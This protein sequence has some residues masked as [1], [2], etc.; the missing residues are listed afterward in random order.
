VETLLLDVL[1]GDRYLL[2]SDGLSQYADDTVL[3]QHLS[4]DLDGIAEELIAFANVS[5]G[6]DNT[7][8]I[9]VSIEAE[10]AEQAA[11][12]AVAGDLQVKFDTL[13]SVFLFEDLPLAHLQRLLNICEVEAFNAGNNVTLQGERCSKMFVVLEGKLALQQDDREIAELAAG[14]CVG[15]ASLLA[16]RTCRCSIRAKEPARLLVLRRDRFASL[17]QKR[18]WF[19]LTLLQRM[20]KRSVHAADRLHDRLRAFEQSAKPTLLEPSDFF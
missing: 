19:G 7:T 2:C 15:E 16:T 9:V 3:A 14:D 13:Q 8:V 11:V 17:V 20:A 6:S 5:G 18:P 4:G 10:E 1:P 12:S